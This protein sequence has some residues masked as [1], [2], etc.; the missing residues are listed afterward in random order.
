MNTQY[1]AIIIGAGAAG[2]MCAAHC[3][4]NKLKTL[5]LEGNA[6]PGMKILISGGG[7]CNFTNK[8]V[9]PENYHSTNRHFHKS[10]IASYTS[11]EFIE[12]VKKHKIDFYEKILGQLF[13]KKSS[14]QIVQLLL[15]E[16]D[17]NF[18]SIKYNEK[19]TSIK[20][21]NDIFLV[22]TNNHS[23]T[24]KQV[25]VATGGLSFSRLGANAS[26][27]DF[28]KS[29]Q[30]E[31]TELTPA[32]VPFTLDPTSLKNF[33]SASG[34]SLDATITVNKKSFREGLL[35]T[36][37][38]LSGPVVLQASL[39]W[40]RGDAI[41]VNLCPDTNIADTLIETKSHIKKIKLIHILKKHLPKKVAELFIEQ[42]IGRHSDT[43]LCNIPDKDL[44]MFGNNINSWI[45]KPSGTEGYNKAEVTRGGVNVKGLHS[46]TLESKLVE[47][48][49][50]IGEVVD[51]TGW[52]GG[53]NFQWAWSSAV[54]AAKNI[55]QK[56]IN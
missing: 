48:L 24:A 46:K 22:Q 14:K 17:Q 7:R 35:F 33:P 54:A 8:E 41:N 1:D 49:Y 29:F 34:A 19:V 9:T 47:G 25:V 20:K 36:H 56:K 10:A 44:K 53:Y 43:D 3:T 39:H 42:F 32:L 5:L 26:G 15:D 4:Q 31:I 40:N 16:I 52:L 28:A 12:L 6:K 37:K 27:Y 2:M 55:V 38:G 13:C 18:G 11:H 23:F 50:F 21:E 45:V 51:V 30:H